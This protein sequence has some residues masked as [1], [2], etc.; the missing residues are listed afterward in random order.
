MDE[1][2]EKAIET[3]V[4]L[5]I[6]P[7]AGVVSDVIGLAGGDYIKEIRARNRAKLHADTKAI[8]EER[9]VDKLEEPNPT[10]IA[11]IITEAQDESR[12][13]LQDIW[14]R[15]LAAALDPSRSSRYRR[16][17]VNA[18]KRLEPTDVKVLLSMRDGNANEHGQVNIVA[19]QSGVPKDQ[20]LVAFESL[21]EAKCCTNNNGNHFPVTGVFVSPLG[22]ELI[23][24]LGTGSVKGLRSG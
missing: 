18:A 19:E 10:I 15:L 20:V 16:E 9:G 8:L 1:I 22:R 13:E 7:F 2:S 5:V 14:A 12:E 23:A 11:P 24:I 3:S 4:G 6:Q 21:I 17:F